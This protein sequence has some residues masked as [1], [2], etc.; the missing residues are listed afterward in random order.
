MIER[1]D[2]P[3]H[4]VPVLAKLGDS[5]HHADGS[6]LVVVAR[7][8]DGVVSQAGIS[9]SGPVDSREHISVAEA[10]HRLAHELRAGGAHHV[11]VVAVDAGVV[12]VSDFAIAFAVP[13][14]AVEGSVESTHRLA[15]VSATRWSVRLSG[16]TR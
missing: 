12:G 1:R 14:G 13:S 3:L 11:P 2:V 5:L 7:A 8:G 4:L 6:G 10:F 15:C 16:T 9:L